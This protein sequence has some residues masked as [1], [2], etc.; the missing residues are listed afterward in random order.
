[1]NKSELTTKCVEYFSFSFYYL[2]WKQWKYNVR[3][4][5]DNFVDTDL[6]KDLL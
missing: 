6:R 5:K 1:M 4:T 2:L 3:A